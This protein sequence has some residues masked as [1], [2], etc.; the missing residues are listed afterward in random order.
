MN[1]E[2][3]QACTSLS[4]LPI[5]GT[6]GDVWEDCNLR[7]VNVDCF[8]ETCVWLRYLRDLKKIKEISASD[9][10][11]FV[12]AASIAID[13]SSIDVPLSDMFRA[14]LNFQRP[15]ERNHDLGKEIASA[16]LSKIQ[17][18]NLKNYDNSMS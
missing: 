15:G 14:H 17:A 7:K 3:F 16:L 8:I 5:Q 11:S 9:L 4:I 6:L 10:K 13:P 18:F 1:L 12:R 2:L